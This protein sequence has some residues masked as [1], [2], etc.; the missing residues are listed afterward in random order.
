M[1]ILAWEPDWMNVSV[2]SWWMSVLCDSPCCLFNQSN[3]LHW[4]RTRSCFLA[5]CEQ[6]SKQPP[7]DQEI[8]AWN[9][10][11]EPC[12]SYA[13]ITCPE[14][15]YVYEFLKWMSRLNK[16]PNVFL[17]R[18]CSRK[19]S[20]LQIFITLEMYLDL[21]YKCKHLHLFV[22]ALTLNLLNR[23]FF[24]LVRTT[25]QELFFLIS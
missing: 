16:I 6:I 11:I 2:I 7:K 17:Q 23:F 12:Y 1:S 4:N 13:F 10:Q 5:M 24:F 18:K 21:G 25:F 9:L 15:V 20:V 22:C 19:K 8:I 14:N 3:I